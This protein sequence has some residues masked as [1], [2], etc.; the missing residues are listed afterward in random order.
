M[1]WYSLVEG[2]KTVVNGVSSSASWI[3][4]KTYLS[5]LSS[6]VSSSVSWIWNKT[7]LPQWSMGVGR[8][9]VNTAFQV[10]EEG[11][12]LR[13]AVPA[14]FT[15][16]KVGEME[17]SAGYIAVHDVLPLTLLYA[18]N[19]GV[20]SYLRNWAD[21]YPVVSIAAAAVDYGVLSYIIPLGLRAGVRMMV[22]GALAPSASIASSP[23]ER[24][25]ICQEQ[26]CNQWAS[27]A[28][29]PFILFANDGLVAVIEYIPLIGKYLAPVVRVYAYGDYINRSAISGR[30]EEHKGLT[31]ESVLASGLIHEAIMQVIN[32]GFSQTIGIPPYLCYRPL[33]QLVLLLE[34]HVAAHRNIP[35]VAPEHAS[36]NPLAIYEKVIDV[37]MNVLY[38]GLKERIPLDF[39]QGEPIVSL[40]TALQ[41]VTNSL[42]SDLVSAP[43]YTPGLMRNIAGKIY[44]FMTPSMLHSMTDFYSD[45]VIH[46]HWVPLRNGVIHYTDILCPILESKTLAVAAWTPKITA[47]AVRTALGVNEKITEMALML[48]REQDFRD[49]AKALKEWFRRNGDLQPI[50]LSPTPTAVI[51][52]YDPPNETAATADDS[53]P[54]PL[55]PITEVQP[56]VPKTFLSADVVTS[57]L[58]RSRAVAPS[59]LVAQRELNGKK[60]VKPH[61]FFSERKARREVRPMD[62]V[63]QSK[64]S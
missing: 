31:S 49:F 1:G 58:G 54:A 61:M 14:L 7:Y 10:L 41:F 51:G 42:N 59:L 9:A 43:K 4:D 56:H 17:D 29:E 27:S 45:P 2:Y 52:L 12:A 15:N 5:Q 35:S 62:L 38:A 23:I 25:S 46:K 34:V 36:F 16:Q 47:L 20:Q 6:G 37:T 55:P 57:G 8:Y 28:K 13:T 30:C 11:L 48:S 19:Y 50:V 60:V 64:L 32:Y 39:P 3:C 33:Q 24:K 22:V 63:T 26:K 44:V 21:A 40:S 53:A 18:A